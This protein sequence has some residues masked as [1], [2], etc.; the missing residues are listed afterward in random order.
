[1]RVLVVEDDRALGAF[2][3]QGLEL[4]G[5]HV[6]L[7]TDGE[8]ALDRVLAEHPDLILL[9]LSLPKRDGME[10]LSELRA[11][12]EDAVVLV[13]TGRSNVDIRVRC[14]D[15]G[16]DDY[17]LKPFSFFELTARCRALLRRH[18]QFADPVLRHGDLELHRLEHKVFRGGRSINLTTKEF[19]LLEYM[20]LRAGKSVSRSE[21]LAQVWQAP[22]QTGTNVVDVY[23]NYLR[24]KVEDGEEPSMIRG[25]LIETVRG[26]GY[27]IGDGGRKSV[28]Q[29]AGRP[30][31]FA[32][33]QV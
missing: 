29:G 3:R 2:L 32:E 8:S 19:A 23:I 28:A 24:R 13:L 17:L 16:A 4:E 14:L 33:L 12:H 10:V 18:Q 15:M 30:S 22:E 1:M 6:E 31:C 11:R 21:L 20:L 7:A 26:V 5:H 9:D 25:G 27:R